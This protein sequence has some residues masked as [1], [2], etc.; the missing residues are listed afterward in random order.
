MYVTRPLSL[1]KK[2]PKSLY[3]PTLEGP[4]SGY[5]VLQDSQEEEEESVKSRC[6]ASTYEFKVTGL[7]F[8]QNALLTIHPEYEDKLYEFLFVPVFDQ[9][10][11][12]NRYYIMIVSKGEALDTSN[13]KDEQPPSCFFCSTKY[14][15]TSPLDPYNTYQQFEILTS[16]KSRNM[17]SAKPVAPDGFLPPFLSNQEFGISLR[18]ITPMLLEAQGLNSSLRASL[19]SLDFSVSHQTSEPLAVGKWHCPFMFVKEGKLKEQI[20]SS[21]Y[22]HLSLEQR[23]EKIWSCNNEGR[24]GNG[25]VDVDV[26]IGRKS[27]KL[28]GMEAEEDAKISDDGFVWFVSKIEREKVGISCILVERILWEEERFG[29]CDGNEKQVC[30]GMSLGKED[31]SQ[32]GCYLLVERFSLKRMDGSLVLSFDFNHTHELRSKWE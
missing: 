6:C 2:T 31:W 5:L 17:F 9:P 4:S 22:Y 28:H 8:P 12:S 7:P 19:P 24:E 23:W 15:N 30:F 20:R 13:S 26:V 18:P 25:R 16:K 3:F 27:V 11:S 14:S 29:W 32:F 1:Y 10:L 21:T